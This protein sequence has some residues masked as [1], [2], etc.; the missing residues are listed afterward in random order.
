MYYKKSCQGERS[1]DLALELMEIYKDDYE[2]ISQMAFND[3]TSP[4]LKNFFIGKAL[5]LSDKDGLKKFIYKN[6][7]WGCN[8]S[9]YG[10]NPI[11]REM[12]S[13]L[14]K[15]VDIE[16][17]ENYLFDCEDVLV[18]EDEV[19]KYGILRTSALKKMLKL[20]NKK[21]IDAYNINQN[22]R[23]AARKQ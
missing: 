1:D 23:E 2:F 13:Y 14:H 11:L 10:P 15:E 7:L 17:W 9:A 22:Y 12:R 6:G 19:R 4:L 8:I 5:S 3:G 18:I 21:V 16:A 20:N